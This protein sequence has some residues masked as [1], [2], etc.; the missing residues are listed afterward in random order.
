MVPVKCDCTIILGVNQEGE[1][2]HIRTN[3]SLGRI[4]KHRR[5]QTAPG[6]P[7]VHRQTAYANRGYVWIRGRR[8]A[9]CE[10]T[11]TSGMLAADNV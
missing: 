7:L 9:S 3:C 4:R 10:G 2:S 1:G 6:K 5:S 8:L 11:S